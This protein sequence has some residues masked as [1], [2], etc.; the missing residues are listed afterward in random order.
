MS[1]KLWI[2]LPLSQQ[3]IHARY[4]AEPPPWRCENGTKRL[5]IRKM[6]EPSIMACAYRATLIPSSDRVREMEYGNWTG[7][8]TNRPY[9]GLLWV[10]I[11]L[12]A[13][14][15]RALLAL[16][17]A[18]PTPNLVNIPNRW[19]ALRWA[20]PFC[21]SRAVGSNP[22]SSTQFTGFFFFFCYFSGTFGWHTG[23]KLAEHTKSM[24]GYQIGIS[25]FLP[26]VCGF[27]S[28]QTPT[29]SLL[30]GYYP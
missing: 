26:K 5:K 9:A 25:V 22:T 29:F 18:L 21:D 17:D 13:N 1:A 7:R 12:E 24:T 10:R 19:R 8:P 16:P 28:H 14:T 23:I 4:A 2:Q 27:K 30:I 11:P 6:H 15:Y 20:Y 3:Y